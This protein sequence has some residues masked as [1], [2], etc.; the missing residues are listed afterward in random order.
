MSQKNDTDPLLERIS[1][2]I[3]AAV[4]LTG[5]SRSRI[6]QLMKDGEIEFVKIGSST[7]IPVDSLRQF[8]EARR[9]AAPR[10]LA[11]D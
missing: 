8:I 1:V 10:S 4:R 7:L 6:Y 11:P 3:P 9:S 2:R 5:M